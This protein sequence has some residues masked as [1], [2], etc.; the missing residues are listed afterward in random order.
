MGRATFRICFSGHLFYIFKLSER[1]A[2]HSAFFQIFTPFLGGYAK[3]WGNFFTSKD[4]ENQ[5]IEYTSCELILSILL[6]F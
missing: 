6:V 5:L 3:F 1:K 4:I 2:I